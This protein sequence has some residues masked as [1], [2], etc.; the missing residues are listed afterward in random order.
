MK[1]L[2]TTM[3]CLLALCFLTG[4]PTDRAASPPADVADTLSAKDTTLD[5]DTGTSAT[6]D[7]FKETFGSDD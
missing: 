6:G 4:C 5:S 3:C 7:A 1:F 2:K